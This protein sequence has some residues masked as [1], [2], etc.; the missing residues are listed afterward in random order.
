MKITVVYTTQVKAALGVPQESIEVDV[1]CTVK[2]LVLQLAQRHG[3]PFR[4]LVLS[5]GDQL[6][7]SILLCVGDQQISC[8]IAIKAKIWH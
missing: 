6:L 7:P 1:P 8:R 2:Q 5:E 4:K 3:E